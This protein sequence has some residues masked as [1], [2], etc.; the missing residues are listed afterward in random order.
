MS[1]NENLS[2]KTQLENLTKK[3]EVPQITLLQIYNLQSEQEKL[4][5]DINRQAE[6]PLTKEEIE[7]VNKIIKEFNQ[8]SKAKIFN[9]VDQ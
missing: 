1:E 7:A 5:D 4:I 8:K 9:F 2:P 3:L 6:S